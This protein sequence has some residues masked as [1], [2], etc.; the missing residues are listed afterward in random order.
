MGWARSQETLV[1]GGELFEKGIQRG[2]IFRGA[3]DA[4]NSIVIYHVFSFLLHF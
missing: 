3:L 4:A 1:F 2:E